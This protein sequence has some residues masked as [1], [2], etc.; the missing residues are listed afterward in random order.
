MGALADLQIQKLTGILN[1]KIKA[2]E[3]RFGIPLKFKAI[4][5]AAISVVNPF[6]DDIKGQLS[7]TLQNLSSSDVLIDSALSALGSFHNI[8]D[9]DMRSYV[10]TN[11][12]LKSI[13]K[14]AENDMYLNT[15]DDISLACS[16]E[17]ILN[18][19]V[20]DSLARLANADAKSFEGA[21][22]QE[23]ELPTK[24]PN[25][26]YGTGQV[27]PWLFL[28][29]WLISNVAEWITTNRYPS[30][31]RRKYLQ[32]VIRSVGSQLKAQLES[33]KESVKTKVSQVSEDIKDKE[34]R[35]KENLLKEGTAISSISS[36]ISS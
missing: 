12:N 1:I 15:A 14:W 9:D 17:E 28:A 10:R 19:R 33:S 35:V 13:I 6:V 30:P 2:E 34:R 32:S 18:S 27:Y 8:S 4:K 5:L 3:L 26:L 29:Y 22:S 25:V 31:N 23:T 11:P 7:S 20:M 24:D 21:L 16:D 36:R